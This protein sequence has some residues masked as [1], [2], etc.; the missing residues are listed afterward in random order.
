[1]FKFNR[2]FSLSHSNIIGSH[3]IFKLFKLLVFLIIFSLVINCGAAIS[4]GKKNVEL[5]IFQSI[6]GIIGD[7]ITLSLLL[8]IPY[9]YI[10][11]LLLYN[12]STVKNKN[13]RFF[14]VS[15]NNNYESIFARLL[16]LSISAF[17]FI[18]LAF[19]NK[20]GYKLL[21]TFNKEY[22]LD[23]FSN[24]SLYPI[25]LIIL[26]SLSITYLIYLPMRIISYNKKSEI[27][28]SS[29]FQFNN[30]IIC[31]KCNTESS[32]YI[33]R[34]IYTGKVTDVSS[35]IERGPQYKTITTNTTY[36]DIRK[37]DFFICPR[38]DKKEKNKL[39]LSS[40]IYMSGFYLI[41]GIAFFFNSLLY[42]TDMILLLVIIII[43]TWI[44]AIYLLKKNE[45]ITVTLRK[46]AIS[47]RQE[48]PEM[49]GKY[50]I[51][52]V[53]IGM[54]QSFN[55]IEYKRLNLTK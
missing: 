25:L 46:L 8:L 9:Y 52:P 4:N 20:G 37:H 10:I 54:H 43:I 23:I 27:D 12:K 30:K 17:F 55:E 26:F 48:Q 39:V 28:D 41:Y 6:A 50:G 19:K 40:I 22:I 14:I 31:D 33:N 1:M 47:K 24:N 18:S 45:D 7:C 16:V 51:D 38:C 2:V 3:Y 34:I 13:K 32:K 49:R 21:N 11:N 44:I 5:N 53:K 15:E 29:N 36:T 42:Q 35:S